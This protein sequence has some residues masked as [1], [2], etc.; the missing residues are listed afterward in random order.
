MP[1]VSRRRFL[2][3]GLTLAGISLVVGCGMSSQ[4]LPEPPR[5]PRIGWL[6]AGAAEANASSL[7]SFRQGLEELGY[8]EGQTVTI[9]GRWSDGRNERLKPLASELV[10]LPVAVIVAGGAVA[11]RAAQESTDT[12]PIVMTLAP[13]PV[14]AGFAESLARPGKNITGIT[15]I[16][17]E[18]AGKRLELLRTTLPGMTRLATLTPDGSESASL[19][20]QALERLT[21]AFGIQLH[22]LEVHG[23][24]ELGEAMQAAQTRNADALYVSGGG[25]FST[26]RGEVVSLAAM[27]RLPATYPDR[28]WVAEGG[29][30]AYAPDPDADFRRAASYV[31]KILKGGK[32]GDLPIERPSKLDLAINLR[33]AQG[34]GLTI[35]APVLQQATEMIQ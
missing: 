32:P 30:M 15:T 33:A 5:I 6:S 27:H 25:L 14:A 22:H 4:Q 13:D 8:V 1:Q 24:S 28:R 35:P 18:L 29:L 21:P 11:I 12:V 31:D 23:P 2:H 10:R 26:V 19:N 9:D 3:N 7:A 17:S 34:L 20:M 16:A